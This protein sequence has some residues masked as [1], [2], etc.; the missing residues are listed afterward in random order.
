MRHIFT[1]GLSLCLVAILSACNQSESSAPQFEGF[2]FSPD[3]TSILSVYSHSDSSFIYR[4]ALDT[5]RAE[6]F[7]NAAAGV[8]GSP[9]FSQDGTRIAYSYSPGKKAPSGIVVA[10]VDGS[11]PHEWIH[12]GTNDYRP[13]FLDNKAIIFARAA[14]Y[15]SYSPVAQPYL[16][17]WNFYLASLD[18]TNA[19]QITNESFYLVSPAHVSPDGKTMIFASAEYKNDVIAIYSLKQPPEPKRNLKPHVPDEPQGGGIFGEP[20]FLPDGKN[21]LFL[22]AS[23][24]ARGAYD[25][26]V[27]RMDLE[28]EKIEKLTKANGYS[29]ALQV[30]PDGKMAVFAKSLSTRPDNKPEI[31]LLDLA[32]RKLSHL[33]VTGLE[34][35]HARFNF[36]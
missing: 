19:R 34:Q 33:T 27:Y 5:G 32:T 29:Y 31:W 20:A 2:A 6:R 30:S 12:P 17:E 35:A 1:R 7:T 23:N 15:G 22:A 16:H 14:Y 21:I 3:G 24:G 11:D 8:E 18:G 25:Y 10:N 4:I 36:R 28:T 9:S 13:L 26:D